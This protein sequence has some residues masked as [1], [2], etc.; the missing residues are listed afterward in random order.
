MSGPPE[1]PGR[2]EQKYSDNPSAEIL[3][4][5]SRAELLTISPR[6]VG[7][8]K[9]KSAFATSAVRPNAKTRIINILAVFISISFKNC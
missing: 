6:F 7:V 2:V 5:N 4:L 8:P 3:S 1:P 9:V